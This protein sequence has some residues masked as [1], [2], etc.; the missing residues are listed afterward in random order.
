MEE[1]EGGT[2]CAIDETTGQCSPLDT[3]GNFEEETEHEG[4][5]GREGETEEGGG[6]GRKGGGRGGRRSAREGAGDEEQQQEEGGGGGRWS[7]QDL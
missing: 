3:R 4:G 2:S 6:G 5:R 7:S 1:E